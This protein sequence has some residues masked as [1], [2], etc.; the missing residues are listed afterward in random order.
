MGILSWMI[1]KELKR[2]SPVRVYIKIIFNNI[3]EWFVSVLIKL[4]DMKNRGNQ[5]IIQFGLTEDGINEAET[6]AKTSIRK[7]RNEERSVR[8]EI[9]DVNFYSVGGLLE[10]YF[11]KFKKN[12]KLANGDTKFECVEPGK[13]FHTFNDILEYTRHEFEKL[14]ERKILKTMAELEKGGIDVGKLLSTG[15]LGVGV[16]VSAG[17]AT[18]STPLFGIG[19]LG[20]I[21]L[22]TTSALMTPLAATGVGAIIGGVVLGGVLYW[23]NN[24]AREKSL[25]ALSDL[26]NQYCERINKMKFEA[27][28]EMK[29]RERK[30]K[31]GIGSGRAKTIN[32]GL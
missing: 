17:M 4:Q 5:M 23:K 1:K 2:I 32:I 15:L 28:K 27:L 21:G 16:G 24:E 10:K 12:G 3:H 20:T 9:N 26:S 11:G 29:E 31:D 25:K 8:L 30:I 19:F 22:T 13:I 6:I 14:G 7:I 18:V